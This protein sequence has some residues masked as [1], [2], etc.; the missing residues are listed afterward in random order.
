[1]TYEKEVQELWM[2]EILQHVV[3]H[4]WSDGPTFP[5]SRV[6]RVSGALARIVGGHKFPKWDSPA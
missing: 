2:E 6:L 1:M 4:R 5:T 3:F